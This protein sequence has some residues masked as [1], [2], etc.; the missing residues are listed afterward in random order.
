MVVA[1]DGAIATK[2][3]LF[4]DPTVEDYQSLIGGLAADNR[5]DACFTKIVILDTYRDGIE[6]ISET[7]AR[8]E[9][10]KAVHILSHGSP[11]CL[12]LGNSQLSR[13]TVGR[14]TTQLRQWGEA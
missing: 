14:Y 13:E 8:N 12:Y 10:L 4:I 1:L 6:Q 11:G 5:Q 7:L 3:I 2:S 9:G